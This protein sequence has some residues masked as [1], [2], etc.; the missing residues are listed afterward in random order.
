MIAQTLRWKLD[1][2]YYNNEWITCRN[3]EVEPIKPIKMSIFQSHNFRKDLDWL[4]L[5]A[6]PWV[7]EKH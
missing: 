5:Y 2:T 4:P 7:Q 3:K 6:D 1:G